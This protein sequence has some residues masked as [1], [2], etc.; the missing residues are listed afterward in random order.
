MLIDR[1]KKRL[2]ERLQWSTTYT[3]L[4]HWWII[5]VTIKRKKQNTL[6][7]IFFLLTICISISIRRKWV[8]FWYIW[9]LDVVCGY[10]CWCYCFFSSL[11]CSLRCVFS[12]IFGVVSSGEWVCVRAW[13]G[14]VPCSNIIIFKY[15]LSVYLYIYIYIYIIYSVLYIAKWM[16]Y[17]RLLISLSPPLS[18]P[19]QL[20][21]ISLAVTLL[22]CHYSIY[23]SIHTMNLWSRTA[24]MR[25]QL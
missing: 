1:E 18:S 13:Y 14:N 19:S 9:T 12:Y 24:H 10:W 11:L 2:E 20:L 21:W 15:S 7:S 4:R 16:L 5:N 17:A 25:A 3:I 8:F 22:C 6:M 23:Y